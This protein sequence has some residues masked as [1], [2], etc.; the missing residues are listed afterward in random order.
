M[1]PRKEVAS[2][3]IVWKR[4]MEKSGSFL[5]V[6]VLNIAI[7]L[8][9]STAVIY[10]FV[11]VRPIEPMIYMVPVKQHPP[12]AKP[13]SHGGNP[14]KSFTDPSPHVVPPPVSA[15]S[16]VISSN[17][18]ATFSLKNSAVPALTAALPTF[19][20][21]ASGGGMATGSSGGGMSHANP[22]GDE[23]K[24]G[25]PAALVGYFYDLKQTSESLPSGISQEGWKDQMLKLTAADLD[26]N[27]LAGYLKSPE[28]RST[29]G[30]A[31]PEQE[32][33]NAPKAFN[34][35]KVKPNLWAIIYH[36][37][38]IAPETGRY[39]FVG[40]GDDVLYIKLNG[41]VVLDAGCQPMSSQ[42]DLHNAFTYLT[43][44]KVSPWAQ[45]RTGKWFDVQQGDEIKLDVL[46]GDWGGFTGFFLMI[47]KDGV[48]YP[49]ASDGKTLRL[50]LFQLGAKIVLPTGDDT[51]PLLDSDSTWQIGS[52]PSP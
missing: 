18:L 39:R 32:S 20:A 10:H 27:L 44:S 25:S 6:L 49:V 7:F 51:P 22:F 3:K 36:G 37:T 4:R 46:I 33:A 42:E 23:I 15:P 43:W 47:Q 45:L 26:E 1:K 41:Q 35:P 16:I 52:H 40:F 31:I 12:T 48:S 50:P 8:M 13:P 29:A 30:F 2:S 28:P 34:L 38:A 11:A 5:G 9:V 21:Q 17:P 19:T 14:N 24:D